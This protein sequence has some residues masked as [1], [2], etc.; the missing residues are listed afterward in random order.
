MSELFD[1]E[2]KH[3]A[4]GFRFYDF[5]DRNGHECTIQK[6]SIATENAI[7]LGLESASPKI[8]HGDATKLGIEHNESSGW[9]DYPIPEEVSMNTRMHLTQDQAMQLGEMLIHFAESGELPRLSVASGTRADGWI[10][11]HD[12]KPKYGTPVILSVNNVVQDITYNLD[13]GDDSLDWFEPYS[14]VG[15]YDDLKDISLFV[16][17]DID[18]KW[19]SLPNPPARK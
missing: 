10:S 8:L 12:K 6:S 5:V 1:A 19:M 7:W 16:T 15:L 18:V 17:H 2:V 4:R 11:V 9:V 3:T 13:G 14:S